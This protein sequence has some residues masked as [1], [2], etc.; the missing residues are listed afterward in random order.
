MY[1]WYYIM[2]KRR[3]KK[4]NNNHN[5]SKS[6]ASKQQVRLI[7]HREVFL[8]IAVQFGIACDAMHAM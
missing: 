2:G 6:K 1:T 8:V 4:V 5:S 3:K 7:L